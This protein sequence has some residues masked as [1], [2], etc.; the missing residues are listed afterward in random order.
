M[1]DINSKLADHAFEMIKFLISLV[2]FV[3]GLYVT[4]LG[5]YF[6]LT[7]TEAI[8]AKSHNILFWF[9]VFISVS[10]VSFVWVI[11]WLVRKVVIRY[12]RYLNLIDGTRQSSS[13]DRALNVLL[14]VG[15]LL[16]IG[17]TAAVGS[18]MYV[19]SSM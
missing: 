6:A 10:T 11:L 4:L 19:V 12:G 9:M 1:N 8:Q 3:A 5:A 2:T 16:A 17:A 18:A 15:T 14:P 7:L 13:V